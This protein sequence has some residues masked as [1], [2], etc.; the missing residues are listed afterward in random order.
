MH[1]GVG[2]QQ[3]L[4]SKMGSIFKSVKI[5]CGLND[6]DM[7]V[8]ILSFFV[9]I[10]LEEGLEIGVKG[11]IQTLNL[12]EV[13]EISNLGQ[14]TTELTYQISR[15]FILPVDMPGHGIIGVF[16]HPGCFISQP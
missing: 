8:F 3:N 10:A 1:D 16:D 13:F 4:L 6:A 12:F 2:D 9:I 11:R 15:M 7:N 14:R 5:N